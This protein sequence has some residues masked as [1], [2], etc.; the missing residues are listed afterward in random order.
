MTDEEYN[1]IYSG[2]RQ[3]KTSAYDTH[4]YSADHY[5]ETITSHA[6]MSTYGYEMTC[7]SNDAL[8]DENGVK[9]LSSGI[10]KNGDGET[11]LLLEL[12]NTTDSMVYL[13]AS[14]IGINGLVVNSSIWSNDAVNSGKRCIVEVL[15][16]SVFDPAY[17]SVYGITD[18]GSVSLSL[19]QRNEDGLEIAT[20]IPVEIVIPGVS[21]EFDTTGTE[22]Y[23]DNGLRIVTKAVLA[24]PSDH[25]AN[26]YVLL[27]AENN[28]GKTLTIDDVYD[29]LSVNGYMTE[30][31][32]Y[33]QELEDGGAA[34][35]V[36]QLRE[37]SLEENQI[38]SPSDIQE[39]EI[40]F[41]IKEGYTAIDEP[42]ITL[43]C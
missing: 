27:L 37:S 19:G 8:Y 14:D 43:F 38:S 17:W 28:S 35:L 34:A 39:I 11:V 21:A 29:S 16:S 18:I 4:N 15:L 13:S 20:E 3:L 22:V 36:I 6:A 33:S 24:D 9:L 30:Y 1:T 42:T 32:Y 2:P 10:M 5:Q 7:F 26:L 25:S 12:E 23:N 41:E 40:G 31:S